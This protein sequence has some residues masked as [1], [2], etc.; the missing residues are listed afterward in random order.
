MSFKIL[1][2]NRSEI[3]LRLIRTYA[4][5]ADV[6]TLAI[7]TSDEPNAPHAL[8]A[9]T[10]VILPGRGPGAYLDIAAIISLAKTHRCSAIAPGYGFLSEDPR[11]AA[12]CED[13]GIVF[14]GPT[15]HQL[16]QLGDKISARS[17]AA[18]LNVPTLEGCTSSDRADIEAFVRGLDASVPVILKAAAGGGGRGIRIVRDRATL[19]EDLA[20]CQREAKLSF[21]D[22]RVYV[23][24][25]L[26]SAKHIEVQL[27]GDGTGHVVAFGDRECSLQRRNQKL[28]EIA[29]SP[30]IPLDDPLRDALVSAAVRLAKAVKYRSLATIEFLVDPQSREFFFMEANPRIQVEHTVTEQVFQVDLV[31]LQLRIGRGQTLAQLGL[32]HPPALPQ[33]RTAIQCRVNSEV[34]QPDGN[35]MPAAGNITALHLPTGPHV[36]IDTA[37]HAPR[38]GIGYFTVSPLFDSLLAKVVVTAPS[39]RQALRLADRSLVE[40]DI[41]GVKTNRAFLLALLRSPVVVESRAIT[42]TVAEQLDALLQMASRIESELPSADADPANA[43][44]GQAQG[45]SAKTAEAPKGTQPIPVHLTGILLQLNVAEGDA[46]TQGQELAVIEAMKMEHVIRS[47]VAGQIAKLASSKG[48]AVMAG[49]ALLFLRPDSHEGSEGPAATAAATSAGA[50]SNEEPIDSIRP[51][52]QEVLERKRLVLDDTRGDAVAK[53]HARGF[54]TV[55]ETIAMLVDAD[56]F[57][58]LGDLVVAAQRQ[59]HSLEHLLARTAGDGIVTGWAT[60]Q[61]QPVALA[62]GDYLVL[63]G[64]QGHFHHLKLDRIFQSVLDHPAPLVLYAEGGGGR[65]GDTDMPL[66]AGL[67]TPSFALLGRIRARGIPSI[68]V[69][70]GYVFAGNAA[71][72]GTCD[73]VIATR[74]GSQAIAGKGRKP[75]K[76]SIGMGGKAMIEGGGLG[77]FESDDIGP[78]EVHMAT[79]G[80]DV[81]VDTEADATR[82]TQRL[83]ALFTGYTLKASWSWTQDARLLRQAVPPTSARR[84]AYDVRA[85]I[86]LLVDDESFIELGAGWGHSIVTGLATVGGRPIGIVANDPATPLGGAIDADAAR[87]ATRLLQLI[88]RTRAAHLVSLCDTPGFMVGP[89]FEKAA[90]GGGSFRIFGDW[91]AAAQSLAL[92]GGR[93]V[94]VVLR[95]AYGL[96]AQAM[97]GGSTLQ[98]SMSVSWPSGAFGGMGLEG[99]VRLGMR[100]ELAAIKDPKERQETEQAWIDELYKRGR[101]TNM[102]TLAEIDSVIDPADTRRWI[103]QALATAGDRVPTYRLHKESRL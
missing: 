79:G 1:I 48:D 38:S 43:S 25:F 70:N 82:L 13:E 59:R 8:A 16:A 11:F 17:L 84:R 36:R 64:T 95:N 98:N 46:V 86:R 4:L 65:P 74:G 73:L 75:G 92:S 39:Y 94:G 103:T 85:V 99:A 6:S 3:A 28:I 57:L 20:A 67:N 21:G 35:A 47:P 33:G 58:E 102:A 9:D 60:V 68:G 2:A 89:D 56:S 41:Q 52:L 80:I 18:K 23:E 27:L 55:R 44:P 14:L 71:L 32:S 54:P 69:A 12:R 62:M 31:D 34:L 78:P 97:L 100:N 63:A 5:H 87:K 90:T 15:S 76:T 72:L 101:A 42:A 66:V 83:L 61:G 37:A 29:P 88:T 53:R 93:V 24:R 81:L 30:S 50:A 40:L 77:I 49:A 45:P 96:G 26:G 22:D 10:A 7:H 91:F 19:G 51:E